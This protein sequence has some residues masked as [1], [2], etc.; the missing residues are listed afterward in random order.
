MTL[1]CGPPGAAR[2]MP[3]SR[4]GAGPA[5]TCVA[6]GVDRSHDGVD[7]LDG[8]ELWLA[9]DGSEPVAAG[10]ILAGPRIGVDY[11]GPDWAGRPWRFGIADSDALSR[12]FPSPR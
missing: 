5:R 11:A 6:L 3:L 10:R 2:P 8:H 1:P 7:L 9:S 4:L 12:P